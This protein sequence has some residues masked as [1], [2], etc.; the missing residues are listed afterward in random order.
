M[1]ARRAGPLASTLFDYHISEDVGRHVGDEVPFTGAQFD[2]EKT[3]SGVATPH[4]SGL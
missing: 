3:S 1:R 2:S 4:A